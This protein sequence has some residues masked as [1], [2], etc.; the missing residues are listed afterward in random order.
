MKKDRVIGVTL[1]GGSRVDVDR[2]VVTAGTG[3][4]PLLEPFSIDPQL[5]DAPGML[6]RTAPVPR[7]SDAIMASPLMDFWQDDDGRVY[8]ATGTHQTMVDDL[9]DSARG[10]M[11]NLEKL[12]PG[13]G[14]A[15]VQSLDLRQRPIP[16]DGMP[17]VGP[18]PGIDGLWTAVSHSGMTLAP[19]IGQAICDMVLGK[20]PGG[21][22]LPFGVGRMISK[23]KR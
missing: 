13:C 2:V 4:S 20:G 23:A 19:V 22:L 8:I 15:E 7:I 12:A 6:L 1:T 3:S 17:V 11:E 5:R 18:V 21:I 14:S 16:G 10:A 9:D